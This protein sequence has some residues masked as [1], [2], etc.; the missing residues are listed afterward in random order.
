MFNLKS[1][2][3]VYPSLCVDGDRAGGLHQASHSSD[4]LLGWGGDGMLGT[5]HC[6]LQP[7]LAD[8]SGESSPCAQGSLLCETQAARR[9]E[10]S[11]KL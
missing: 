8:A 5:N 9:S 4:E 6:S 10:L 3:M 2:E 11:A 7:D 1:G